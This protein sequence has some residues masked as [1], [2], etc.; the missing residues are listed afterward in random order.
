MTLLKSLAYFYLALF[1]DINLATNA[2]IN[3][4]IIQLNPRLLKGS[5]CIKPI[6]IPKLSI[7]VNALITSV[8]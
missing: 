8:I 3:A 1:L 6:L 4:G 2:P 7:T 5:L